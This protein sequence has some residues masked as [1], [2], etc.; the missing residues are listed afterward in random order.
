MKFNAVEFHAFL[1]F[2]SFFRVDLARYNTAQAR[3]RTFLNGFEERTITA[4][5]FKQPFRPGHTNPTREKRRQ[6]RIGVKSAAKFL[7]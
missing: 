1:C 3:S 7:C 5:W 4:T 2:G 6:I